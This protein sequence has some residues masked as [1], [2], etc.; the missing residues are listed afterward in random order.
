M[1]EIIHE[2]EV[3]LKNRH[4]V[5][6]VNL[7]DIS[8][9]EKVKNTKYIRVVINEEKNILIKC[10]IKKCLEFL[11]SHNFL[12]LEKSIVINLDKISGIQ[13]ED[14]P[15][16]EFKDGIILYTSSRNIRKLKQSDTYNHCG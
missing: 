14:L 11:N 9:I 3:L 12:K 16:I 8:Y 4:E 1:V 7:D 10:T 6:K 5:L 2:D 15:Y 13:L